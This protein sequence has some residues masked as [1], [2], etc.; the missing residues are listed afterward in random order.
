[1]PMGQP[2]LAPSRIQAFGLE[3]RRLEQADIEQVRQW[4]NDPAV[5]QF[6][7]SRTL[8]TPE[9]QSRWFAGLDRDRQFFYIVQAQGR[10]VG[11]VNLKDYDASAR[12]AEGGIYIAD[13]RL[14]DGHVGL[15]AVLAMY[16]WGFLELGLETVVAH[17]LSTNSRAIRFNQALGFVRQPGQEHE[18]NQ[19]YHLDR[20][21]YLK[22]TSRLKE[23]LGR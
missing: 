14:R 10:D 23:F 8:I 22:R 12:R 5:S 7:Q 4:R 18:P 15:A 16:D 13:T 1:M 9:M 2:F 17:I 19:L 20:S 11:L 21:E 6:M 3:L